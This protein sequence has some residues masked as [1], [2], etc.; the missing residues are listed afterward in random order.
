M[1]TPP[2]PRSRSMLEKVIIAEIIFAAAVFLFIGCVFYARFL[3]TSPVSVES[4]ADSA[5]AK[6][7]RVDLSKEQ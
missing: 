2:K 1:E 6:S 5:T 4:T 7:T 3:N